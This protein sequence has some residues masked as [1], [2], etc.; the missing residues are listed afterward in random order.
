MMPTMSDK[1]KRADAVN[2]PRAVWTTPLISRLNANS[3]E[4]SISQGGSD[5]TFTTS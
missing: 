1:P 4:N 3:A 5:G 2:A